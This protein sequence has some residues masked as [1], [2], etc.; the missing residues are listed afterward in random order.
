MFGSDDNRYECLVL[1]RAAVF[2]SD[3]DIILYHTLKTPNFESS[4]PHTN[5]LSCGLDM[6]TQ[7]QLI[8]QRSLLRSQLCFA[9]YHIYSLKP[10][11][12]EC[13]PTHKY[14]YITGI[15]GL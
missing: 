6:V 7:V 2:Y 12:W 1:T 5:T 9:V 4:C 11:F 15:T 8:W 14:C 10:R 3:A 13:Q